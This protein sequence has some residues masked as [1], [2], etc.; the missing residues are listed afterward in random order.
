M[1]FLGGYAHQPN[2]DAITTFA[3]ETWP[4]VRAKLPG[5]AIDRRGQQSNSGS[6]AAER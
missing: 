4:A 3:A 6:L 2:V 5:R 1:L